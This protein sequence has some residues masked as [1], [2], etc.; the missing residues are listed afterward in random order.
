MIAD[1]PAQGH[2][3]WLSRLLSYA[4]IYYADGHRLLPWL[5]P[6]LTC[7]EGTI[8]WTSSGNVR[9]I[10]HNT[11]I[12]FCPGAILDGRP[13]PYMVWAGEVNSPLCSSL[14][15]SI[16]CPRVFQSALHTGSYS[17]RDLAYTPSP[18]ESSNSLRGHK[19][20]PS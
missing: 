6:S 7:E 17:H 16:A 11:S 4:P 13:Q 5:T 9:S 10:D 18:R 12:S 2:D 19:T 20:R 3:P 15:M 14:T 1:V 8:A